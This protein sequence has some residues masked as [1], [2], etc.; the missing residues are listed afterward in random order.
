VDVRTQ[1]F[2][3]SRESYAVAAT[4]KQAC[5]FIWVVFDS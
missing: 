2:F 4:F 1:H 5:V 3:I